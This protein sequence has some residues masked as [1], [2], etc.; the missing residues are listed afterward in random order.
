MEWAEVEANGKGSM[1]TF[2]Q[3]RAA[4]HFLGAKTTL[5]GNHSAGCAVCVP[6][7]VEVRLLLVVCGVVSS[8]F[9][10][11]H[12]SSVLSPP[13]PLFFLLYTFLPSVPSNDRLLW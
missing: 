4:A 8:S 5:I 10:S 1:R 3:G 11:T 12:P 6:G 13:P 9:S 2:R 7:C